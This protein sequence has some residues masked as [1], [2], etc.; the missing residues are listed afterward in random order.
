MADWDSGAWEAKNLPEQEPKKNNGKEEKGTLSKIVDYVSKAAD[1]YVPKSPT[2]K[3]K[4]TLAATRQRQGAG[5]YQGQV[6]K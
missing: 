5:W 2:T 6:E 3:A 4:D 1:K